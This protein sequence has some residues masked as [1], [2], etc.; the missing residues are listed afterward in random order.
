[1]RSGRTAG[2]VKDSPSRQENNKDLELWAD[3][4]APSTESTTYHSQLECNG[5]VACIHDLERFAS[6]GIN[7]L[8][9]PV[10]SLGPSI[11]AAACVKHDIQLMNF[12]TIWYLTGKNLLPTSNPIRFRPGISMARARRIPRKK[13]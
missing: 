6:L 3:W 9:Y 13:Y 10:L 4:N 8:R 1:M 7:A 5:H 11:L 2:T 12:S